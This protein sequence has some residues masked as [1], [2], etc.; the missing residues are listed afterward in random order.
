MSCT[1]I[2]KMPRLVERRLLGVAMMLQPNRNLRTLIP[3]GQNLSKNIQLPLY[4]KHREMTPV[5]Q[6]KQ[7]LVKEPWR[8]RKPIE[9]PQLTGSDHWKRKMRTVF[10]AL[11]V[12]GDGC[13]TQGD[14]EEMNR[15]TAEYMNL[16]DDKTK[17]MLNQRRTYWGDKGPDKIFE[18]EFV[19]SHL[20]KMNEIK[21][22]EFWFDTLSS[23]F[24][25]MDLN[26]DG[27]IST[28]EHAAM[29]YSYKIPTEH[30]KKVFDMLDIDNDG[31]ISVEEFAHASSEFWFTENPDNKFNEFFGPL[32]DI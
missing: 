10:R 22:R 5:T 31:F 9:Y 20:L 16:D 14:M 26:G 23:R 7:G 2:L 11:D 30:S 8:F 19:E 21:F 18:D 6:F 1:A 17:T 28:D 3:T 25:M 13:I 15:R 12:N 29:F 27:L 4:D 24:Q 32:V